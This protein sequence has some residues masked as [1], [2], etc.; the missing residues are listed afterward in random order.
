LA[1]ARQ[2]RR[3]F[4]PVVTERYFINDVVE[5][6]MGAVLRKA[7]VAALHE[8]ATARF[9]DLPLAP[10]PEVM[11][12]VGPEGGID[13]R[14]L[15]LLVAAGARPVLLGPTVLRTSTAAAVALGALG[16]L[17]SRWSQRPPD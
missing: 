11:M 1:A 6:V 2:S 10:A 15:D 4:V 8:S 17:T 14:E 7:V 12:I 13:D 9:T 3:A 16:A 5:E